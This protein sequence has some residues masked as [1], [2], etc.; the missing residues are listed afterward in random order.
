MATRAPFEASCPAQA[1]PMPAADPVTMHTASFRIMV[2]SLYTPAGDGVI[3]SLVK[4]GLQLSFGLHGFPANFA[5]AQP[6]RVPA[7][8]RLRAGSGAAS[9]PVLVRYLVRAQAFR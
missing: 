7:H 2:R 4:R 5:A 3:R 9:I 8:H 6:P 1:A